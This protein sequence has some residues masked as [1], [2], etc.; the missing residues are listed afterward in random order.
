MKN[1]AVKASPCKYEQ[2]EQVIVQASSREE[3]L[4]LAKPEFESAK[5]WVIPWTKQEYK[6]KEVSPNKKLVLASIQKQ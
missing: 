1:Y 4:E 5:D 2:Y 3:A 6:V